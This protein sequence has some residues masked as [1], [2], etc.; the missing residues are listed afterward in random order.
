MP[1]SWRVFWMFFHGIWIIFQFSVAFWRSCAFSATWQFS[2]DP[3]LQK[4]PILLL[5]SSRSLMQENNHLCTFVAMKIDPRVFRPHHLFLRISTGPK[6]I[7]RSKLTI[8]RLFEKSFAYL[9]SNRRICSSALCDA[10][11]AILATNGTYL[12]CQVAENV[13]DF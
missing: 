10:L 5:K 4:L 11:E 2:Y 13:H 8:M 1:Y 7:F 9:K 6:K 12:N 3:Y